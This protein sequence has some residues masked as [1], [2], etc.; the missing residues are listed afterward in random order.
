MLWVAE[1]VRFFGFLRAGVSSPGEYVRDAPEL[2][3]PGNDSHSNPSL[4][5]VRIKQSKTDLFRKGTDIYVGATI[6]PVRALWQYLAV[7][8]STPSPLFKLASGIPLTQF[9]L[10]IH[11][12]RA[13]QDAGINAAAYNRHSFRI[14]CRCGNNSCEVQH[15]GLSHPDIRPLE[16]HS[17]SPLHKTSCEYISTSCVESI[18]ITIRSVGVLRHG[19][20]AFG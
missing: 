12:H 4:I 16:E 10:V 7:R 19:P 15:W 11:M 14:H 1:C 13:L 8:G 17:L 9:V 2:G 6:C 18:T 20:Q 5:R 3:Q